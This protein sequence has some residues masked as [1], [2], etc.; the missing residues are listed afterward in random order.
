MNGARIVMQPQEHHL[1]AFPLRLALRQQ[2][3]FATNG[4]TAWIAIL[5]LGVTVLAAVL[6]PVLGHPVAN[7]LTA[8]VV[9]TCATVGAV[10]VLHRPTNPVGWILVMGTLL[11]ALGAFGVELAIRNLAQ[12]RHTLGGVAEAAVL[13]T[14]ARA[15]GWTLMVTFL[16]LLFP[17]GRLPSARWRPVAYGAAGYLGLW[18]ATAL[19]APTPADDRFST[20]R[21]PFGI[22]AASSLP[23]LA[24]AVS[25]PVLLACGAALIR[26]FVKARGEERE[27]L[28][29]LAYGTALPV[30]LISVV[31]ATGNSKLPWQEA[32]VIIPVAIGVAILRYHLYDIDL[33]INRTLVY[34]SL[35]SCVVGLYV[36]VVS[37]FGALFQMRGSPL[38]AFLAAGLV[39]V[40]F[41]PLR[42][43]LQRSVN[44]M[45]YGRRDDPY[46]VVSSLGQRLEGTLS[47]EAVLPNVVDT[48]QE[49]LKLP[50]VGIALEDDGDFR[51]AAGAR[52]PGDRLLALPLVYQQETVGH[53]LVTPRRGEDDLSPADYRL[54][55]DLA[56]QAGAAVHAVQ[57]TA[58]LQRAR[59]RLVTAREEERR[60]L[61]RD[62]HDGLGPQLGSQTLTLT[63]VRKLLR[64]DPDVAERLLDDAMLHAEEAIKDIRRL[65]YDLRPP[66]LDDLG[67]VCS[68]QETAAQYGLNG[69]Q[70]TVEAPPS[71]PPLPAA[72]EV[73]CYRIAHEALTN[74]VRHARAKTCVVRLQVDDALHLEVIDDGVGLPSDYR[75][76]VGVL[77]MRERA[78]ELSGSC[79]FDSCE[80]GGTAIRA[81]L[82]LPR[83]A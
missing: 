16:P 2:T 54:L 41:Q 15:C 45:M 10:I 32:V 56:R 30:I 5:L 59:E 34:G 36:L 8:L 40:L 60:R 3:G 27:Q 51:A 65:V 79:L 21:N 26:R 47:P 24:I 72:V 68:L 63:A 29:W 75:A 81:S 71:L 77:S 39:A 23:N 22:Q 17:S 70:V 82:P 69:L 4:W 33:L 62:L 25:L 42:A 50:Y 31:L 52:R 55:G 35:T 49:A 64:H 76:G 74:V 13:G 83:E 66:A 19:L 48:V 61:R 38:I 37:G 7:A 80:G 58:E 44:R 1:R 67:L 11:W 46:A 14:W 18:T 12:H 53:F 78:V 57:L 43:A 73:A 20:V 6:T 28:K 9:I